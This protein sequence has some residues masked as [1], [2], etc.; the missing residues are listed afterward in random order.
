MTK[1][2]IVMLYELLMKASMNVEVPMSWFDDVVSECSELTE[3]EKLVLMN[4]DGSLLENL[5]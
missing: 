3:K 2:E 1:L 4:A 5:K